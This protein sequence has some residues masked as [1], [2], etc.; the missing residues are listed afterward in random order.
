MIE[1]T[2]SYGLTPILPPLGLCVTI[3]VEERALAPR[4]LRDPFF[5]SKSVYGY[6]DGSIKAPAAASNDAN[7][8]YKRKLNLQRQ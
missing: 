7:A 6:V 3:S 2:K 4:A 5:L 1:S 8:E